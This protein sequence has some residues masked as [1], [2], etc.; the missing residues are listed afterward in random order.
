MTYFWVAIGGALG[1]VMR[2]GFSGLITEVTGGFFPY[3]TMFVNVT[4]ALLIGI[5]ASLAAPD[6]RYFIPAPARLF[7]MTGICGGYTTFS[8]FSLES[9]NLL[10]DGE[11]IPALANMLLSVVLCVISVWIGYT[12]V[13][14]M[15]RLKGA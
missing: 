6:S 10:R 8:T 3:G 2:F 9:F 5:I 1:S 14:V 7:L 11:V 15:S 12:S 4:G 13:M